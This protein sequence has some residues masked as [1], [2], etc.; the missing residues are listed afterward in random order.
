MKA[1]VLRRFSTPFEL[2]IADLA[3]PVPGP[4]EI[5][6]RVHAAGLA[7]GETLIF[8]G[9]Y[10][11]LPALPYVPSNEFAGVVEACGSRVSAFAR[12][13]R[14]MG[15][16]LALSGGGLAEYCV[17]PEAFV[18]PC[19]QRLGFS[20][21]A[22]AIMNYWTSF[23]ALVRR[24]DLKAGETLVVHGASGGV[25]STAVEI[26]RALGARVIA[27]GGDA[28][29]L[30]SVKADHCIDTTHENVRDRLLELTGGRGADVYFDPVGGDLFDVS[31]RAIAPGGRILVVG[32]TSG[33]PAAARTNII[34]VKMIS[35]I[36]VEARLAIET[37]GTQGRL[38]FEEMLRWIEQGR[39]APKA[40][41]VLP[42]EAAQAGYERILA[43]KH[44]GKLVVAIA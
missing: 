31:M 34:L 4:S 26:G 29:R 6:I 20:D 3:I 8:G 43:R 7:F 33:R 9:T 40:A 16:S 12:G 13:D 28:Q 38:D 10:Q 44:T 37:M 35:V 32:F 18:H 22:A 30:A 14:V 15:F 17:M 19:P 39:L 23:N 41:E 2:E 36:G 1:W 42:F 27:T 25:G 21:A 5:L 24:G 11:K